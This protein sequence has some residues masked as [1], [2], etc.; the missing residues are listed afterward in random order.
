LHTSARASMRAQGRE[1]SNHAGCSGEF[2]VARGTAA[3]LAPEVA[4]DA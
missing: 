2:P 4:D 3:P 1:I